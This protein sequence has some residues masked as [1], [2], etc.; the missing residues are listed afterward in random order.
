M[1]RLGLGSVPLTDRA[2]AR[3]GGPKLADVVGQDIERV[4]R[5]AAHRAGEGHVRQATCSA[6][7]MRGNK[8]PV[9]IGGERVTAMW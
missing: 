2:A 8:S 9:A 1:R 5:C 3:G 4:H 7:V 6:R